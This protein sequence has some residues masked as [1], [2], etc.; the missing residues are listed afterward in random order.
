M[1]K[2]LPHDL[3][4]WQPDWRGKITQ[5]RSLGKKFQILARALE[6]RDAELAHFYASLVESEG[7]HYANYLLMA[8]AIEDAETDRRLDWYLDLDAQLIRHPNPHPMRH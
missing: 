4:R 2:S 1:R 6:N 3:A 5:Q 7:N 8:R